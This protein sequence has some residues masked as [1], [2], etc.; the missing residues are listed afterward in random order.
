LDHNSR[1]LIVAVPALFLLVLTV[2]SGSRFLASSFSTAAERRSEPRAE[3]LKEIAGYRNWTRVNTEPQLMDLQAARDCAV[4]PLIGNANGGINPH[5]NKYI[6]V[7]VNATGREAMMEKRNPIFPEGSAIVKEKLP[8]QSSQSP[9]LL[10]VMIK[11][12]KGFNPS[13]GDWEFMVVDG[14]GTKVESRGK[15]KNCQG[16]HLARPRSDYIFR[17]YLPD[18][19][20]NNLK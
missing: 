12:E 7:Y 3:E 1:K 5:Q 17:S 10:T 18:D 11:R 6:L 8:D 2:W 13:T 15:L 20:S 4:R 9:E 19:V 16:C 14:S